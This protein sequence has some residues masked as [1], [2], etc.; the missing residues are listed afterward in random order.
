MYFSEV[1][2]AIARSALPAIAI[3]LSGQS[4]AWGQQ[5]AELNPTRVHEIATMLS[6]Q[7]SGFGA[8][9]SDRAAWASKSDRLKSVLAQAEAA[10]N[11]P[12]AARG[13]RGGG[14][15]GGL[16]SLVLA[17]CVEY[18]GRFIPLI[19]QAMDATVA[20]PRWTAA[21]RDPRGAATP[22]APYWVDLV[23]ADSG[24]TLAEAMYLLGDAIPAD[25]RKRA[26]DGVEKHIF[27]PMRRSYE[28]GG[29]PVVGAGADPAQFNLLQLNSNWWLH[30][31]LNWNAVCLKGVTGAALA[32]LPSVEDRAMFVAAAEHYIEHYD[33]AFN[34]DGYGAEGLH[35][36]NYGFAHFIELRE[37]LIRATGGRIDLLA[38][39]KMKKVALFGTEFPML[40][41]NAASYGDAYW[42]EKPDPLLMLQIDNIFR[43]PQSQPQAGD[44]L[45]GR[46]IQNSALT[47][48]CLEIF[49]IKGD[50]LP[51]PASIV[52]HK[53]QVYYADSGVLV[54]RAA[55]GQNFAVTIK[56]GGNTT[57]SHNDIGSFA[58]GMGGTQPVGEPGGPAFY[59][60]ETFSANRFNSKLLNSFGHPVPEIDGQLQLDATTVKVNVITQAF[61]DAEDRFT[62]DITK[63]YAVPALKQAKRTMVHSRAGRG[64]VE[65]TDEFDIGKGLEIVESLPTHGSWSKVDEKTLLFTLDG[66][67]V[68]VT[69]EAPGP[70]TI[71]ETKVD[72]YRNPFT[73][74]EIH[75]PLAGSGKV[76]M[77]F[78][79]GQ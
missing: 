15:S 61:S 14:A 68:Q 52:E 35:Y 40:P 31:D 39:E 78:T 49:P 47:A 32:M 36:W 43:N 10:L 46:G 66:E 63:A 41:G 2:R 62:M 5:F 76:T 56:A 69:I 29:D 13:G 28:H 26:A 51:T 20:R 75:V 24:D 3:V 45:P 6:A 72:E 71:S 33:K 77:R 30:G 50:T 64:S 70:V 37:N 25:V 9:C 18:K 58:I 11:N 8:P 22:D 54:S 4:E 19:S 65:I 55:P 79:P 53:R 38:S 12:G 48:R 59:N 7:P 27:G 74:V 60:A 44:V 73:R 23:S 67:K 34:A 57:H 16:D 1:K 17:E 42:M 21:S